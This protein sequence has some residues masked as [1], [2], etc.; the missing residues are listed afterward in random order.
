MAERERL[1]LEHER[2]QRDQHGT[3]EQRQYVPDGR[4]AVV[5]PLQQRAV[6]AKEPELQ[7]KVEPKAVR[8]EGRGQRSPDLELLDDQ[9]TREPERRSGQHERACKAGKHEEADVQRRDPAERRSAWRRPVQPR[10]VGERQQLANELQ[11]GR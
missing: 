6:D 1:A 9:P 3:A 11:H 2:L 10:K 8:P 7:R 4:A 5:A